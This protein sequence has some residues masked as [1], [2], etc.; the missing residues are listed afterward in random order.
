MQISSETQVMER[1]L[2]HLDA[3]ENSEVIGL[4]ITLC[5][6]V[7]GETKSLFK[8]KGKYYIFDE[9]QPWEF[10]R[11]TAQS[12]ADIIASSSGSFWVVDSTIS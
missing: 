6:I 10:N 5:S 2:D 11:W 4:T 9:E 7:R 8:R 12:R 3:V 1:V